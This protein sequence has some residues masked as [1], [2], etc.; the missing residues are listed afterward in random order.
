M[1]RLRAAPRERI[2]AT[3][4]RGATLTT[5]VSTPI[6]NL[7]RRDVP[8]PATPVARPTGLALATGAV[9]RG[10]RDPSLAVQMENDRQPAVRQL[11]ED[12]A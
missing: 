2:A 10:P 11:E 3:C 5:V 7:L 9:I 8:S 12:A 6:T 4:R 1:Q